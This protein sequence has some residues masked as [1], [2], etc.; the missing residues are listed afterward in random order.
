MLY[1]FLVLFAFSFSAIDCMSPVLAKPSR[2]KKSASQKKRA[3]EQK[4]EALTKGSETEND[5]ANTLVAPGATKLRLLAKQA[6]LMDVRTG[7]V[8]LEKN[9]DQAMPP[10]SMSKMMTS[11]LVEEKIKK[12]E[13][14][15]DTQYPVSEKAWRMGGSKMFVPL[16][17]IV[18]VGDLLKGIIIQS[19]NDACIVVA[20]GISGSEE[21]FVMEMN[22]SAKKM[23]L[24]HTQ[25]MNASGWPQEGHYSTARDLALL[26]IRVAQDHPDT[27]KIYS[28]KDFTFGTDNKG[29]PIKQGNRNPLLYKDDMGCDGIKTGH[30]EDGGYGIVASFTDSGQRYMMV[31][32]GLK[33]MRQRSEE[34]TKILA[35][36]KQNFI[37]K[38]IYKSGDIVEKEAPVWLG[39][40]ETVPL[41]VADD[42]SLLLPRSEQDK[43]E[44]KVHF[45]S[46]L[47]APLKKGDAMGKVVI[48]AASLQ[49]EVILIAAQDVEKVGFFTR[50]LRSLL[51]LIWGKA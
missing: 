31:I 41:V 16:N 42:V 12:G 17:G 50:L 46:P 9:A 39:V 13:L 19:G 35:W 24:T 26:G 8:L 44:M 27:Y 3:G 6:I 25:F 51:Y 37:N 14:T 15:L 30:T 48:T 18:S 34:A 11:Y 45:E 7:K 38:Q 5:D 29:R 2:S 10:S 23:G 4:E 40:K 43:V 20:E 47:P 1:F 49:H 32:N 33:T 22:E 28:E 36:V 21:A